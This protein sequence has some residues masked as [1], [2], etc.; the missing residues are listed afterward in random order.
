[1]PEATKEAATFSHIGPPAAY[2]DDAVKQRFWDDVPCVLRREG[3]DIAI[4]ACTFDD[5]DEIDTYEELCAIDPSY[6]D[7]PAA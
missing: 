2:E 5:V 4:R 7:W 6:L 1:M 3:Y